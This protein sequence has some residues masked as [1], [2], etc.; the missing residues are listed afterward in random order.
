[1]PSPEPSLEHFFDRVRAVRDGL[2]DRWDVHTNLRTVVIMLVAGAVAG[3]AY[4]AYIRPPESFPVGAHDDLFDCLARIAD[5]DIRLNWPQT[6]ADMQAA[7]MK[8]E[9]EKVK[10]SQAMQLNEM[11]MQSKMRLQQQEMEMGAAQ[12]SQEMQMSAPKAT[13]TPPR[14]ATARSRIAAGS[15]ARATE[16]R[17]G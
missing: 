16:A 15:A 1:M 17:S 2:L 4:L 12:K 13:G 14:G 11:E 9:I 3:H 8:M 7:A 5:P 10:A 6:Q